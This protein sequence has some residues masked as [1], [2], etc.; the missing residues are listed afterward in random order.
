MGLSTPL[1]AEGCSGTVH[2]SS[3]RQEAQATLPTLGASL[4]SP[5][6]PAR[7]GVLQCSN[8][9]KLDLQAA[10]HKLHQWLGARLPPHHVDGAQGLLA[11]H[12]QLLGL[13]LRSNVSLSLF[14]WQWD[15]GDRPQRSS[16]PGPKPHGYSCVH[17]LKTFLLPH[18]PPPTTFSPLAGQP[19]APPTIHL[20]PLSSDEL[21]TQRK[22]TL[23]CLLGDFY[24][25]AVQVTW[26]ADGRTLSSGTETSQPQWQTNNQ[27]TASSYLTLSVADWRSRKTYACKVTHETS[28]IKKV[29]TRSECS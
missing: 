19:K 10:P 29:L 7:G 2:L 20:F 3:R 28:T 5:H 12:K 6:G 13:L 9:A 26:T 17:T 22:A 14:L 24:P 8:G 4:A 23:V 11:E 16:W 27:Y 15:P 18:P 1:G 25:G 21:S